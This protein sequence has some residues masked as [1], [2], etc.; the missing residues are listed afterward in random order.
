MK[1][2]DFG[3]AARIQSPNQRRKT[4]CGTPNYIAP[5]ILEGK[6][7]SYEVDIWSTGVIL[8][9]LLYGRPPFETS[10]V[11]K[12]YKKIRQCQ[13]AFNDDISISNNAKNL[14]S[15][16]LILDPTKRLTLDQ[17]K[18]HPFLNDS[19]MPETLPVSILNQALP[20]SFIESQQLR[21]KTT[22]KFVGD[23]R[24]QS[25]MSDRLLRN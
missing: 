7:H 4:I 19:K 5:E 20:K 25:G 12:T 17:I 21:R 9:A 15:K 11:K 1:I 24:I 6:G 3:L 2:G 18:S 23:S 8:Y 22:E 10:D 14:I 13:Y 16:L